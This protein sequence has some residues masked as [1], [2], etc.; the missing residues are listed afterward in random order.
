MGLS[1][2]VP[3]R[4]NAAAKAGLLDVVDRAVVEGW[5]V[6][7]ACRYLELSTR[8]CERWRARATTGSLDDKAPGGNPVHGITPTEEAEIV[9]VFNEWAAVD[10]SH[11]KLAHR[12]S[13][14]E[15]FWVDPSTVKRVLQRHDLRFRRPPR[16]GNSK[17]KL[18]PDW[19]EERPNSVWIYDTTHWTKSAAAT[20]VIT[21]VISKKWIA[22]IT[23]SEETSIQVQAVFTRALRDEGFLDL[24]EALTTT[25]DAPVDIDDE[26]RPILLVMSDNGPQM[27]SGSTREFMALHM[28]ATHYG[29]PGTPTDQAWVESFFGHLKIEHPHLELIADIDVLRAELAIRRRHYNAIR[30]HA[31]IGYVTPNQEHAGLGNAVRAARRD[32]LNRAR[33]QRITYHQDNTNP[34]PH[35]AD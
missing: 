17:R 26:H 15:R 34:G 7:R 13:W 16:Q 12:G 20:T 33:Q 25:G 18:W 35:H 24:I 19:V 5:P 6:A 32:G 9:A 1:G 30:L 22:E 11:R 4:V 21:D 23:S 31:G 8:R 14:L 2:R 10:R 28:L 3:R 29:R 27:T